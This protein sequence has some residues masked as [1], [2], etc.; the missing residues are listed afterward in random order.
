MKISV[1]NM[2]SGSLYKYTVFD[3]FNTSFNYALYKLLRQLAKKD[4]KIEDC[5][6]EIKVTAITNKEEED[7]K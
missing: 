6:F 4:I 5:I 3:F 7:T 1:S 2:E